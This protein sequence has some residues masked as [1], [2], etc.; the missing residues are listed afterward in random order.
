MSPCFEKLFVCGKCGGFLDP[1]K[2]LAV[3]LVFGSD[4]YMVRPAVGV[5]FDSNINSSRGLSVEQSEFDYQKRI[6]A[7]RCL[8]TTPLPWWVSSWK[9]G[10]TAES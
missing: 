5:G 9:L 6:G 4:H 8:P 7:G 10:M 1:G 2:Q 3:D